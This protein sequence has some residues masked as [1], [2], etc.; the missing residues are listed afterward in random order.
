MIVTTLYRAAASI[1]IAAGVLWSPAH[2]QSTSGS[3]AAAYPVKP[4]RVI[5]PFAPGGGSDIT[6]RTMS[7]KLSE[8]FG[9]PFVPENRPGAGGLV[10][11]EVAVKAAPDGY[12][13]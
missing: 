13:I 9:H 5:I 12:T 1:A 2:A 7:Q 6:A 10:G 3:A 11:A 8:H 4:V